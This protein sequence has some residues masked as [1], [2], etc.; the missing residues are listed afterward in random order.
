MY[1][2]EIL[3]KEHQTI[4][5]MLGLLNLISEK[6][7][8]GESLPEDDLN[9]AVDFIREFADRYHHGKEEDLLFPALEEAGLPRDGGPVAVMLM[10][11]VQGREF[12]KAMSDALAQKDYSSFTVNARNYTRLLDQH[13]YKEDNIL[14]PMADRM[15]R[16]EQQTRLE[17]DYAAVEEKLNGPQ[18]WQEARDLIQSLTDRYGG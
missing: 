1:S 10:E 14:Y 13:I 7:D 6:L 18:R 16:P 4:R 8:V 12:V 17:Q 11:H 3:T 15:L 9:R 5:Q 2:T